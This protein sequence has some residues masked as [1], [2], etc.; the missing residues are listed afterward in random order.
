LATP[1]YVLATLGNIKCCI[2]M[3]LRRS[4]KFRRELGDFFR[5]PPVIKERFTNKINN[6]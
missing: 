5:A 3:L 1:R 4:G 6:L 2:A